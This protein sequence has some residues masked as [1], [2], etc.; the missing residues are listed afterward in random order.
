MRFDGDSAGSDTR[1]ENT[2]AA[3][4]RHKVY[5][6]DLDAELA[7]LAS[8]SD[9]DEGDYNSNEQNSPA[10]AVIFLPDIER[11][12][13]STRIPKSVLRPDDQGMFAGRDA[14]EMQ[15]VVYGEAPRS[16]SVPEEQ[17][18]VRRA[19]IEARHRAREEGE[20]VQERILEAQ[21]KVRDTYYP[22]SQPTLT[23][24]VLNGVSVDNMSFN[25]S[26]YVPPVSE[27][28]KPA[29]FSSGFGPAAGFLGT[30]EDDD[31]MD[32]DL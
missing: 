30:V 14:K 15:L 29:R 20:R 18:G 27:P 8:S 22:S 4:D 26:T 10:S 12:L 16:L 9:H 7:S 5:I 2:N 11:H 17:D 6:Y 31:A 1:I 32:I 24:D 23:Q 21:K 25:G 28:V 13:R 3:D 19:I